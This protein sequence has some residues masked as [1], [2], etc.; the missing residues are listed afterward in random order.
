VAPGFPA[1]GDHLNGAPSSTANLDVN[2]EQHSLVALHPG[3]V[4]PVFGG[5]SMT[6]LGVSVKL[7]LSGMTFLRCIPAVPAF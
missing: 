3:H 7:T 6:G 4:H 1:A 5:H 2:I